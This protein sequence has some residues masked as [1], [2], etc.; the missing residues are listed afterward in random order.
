MARNI[1][2]G[3]AGTIVDN[4]SEIEIKHKIEELVIG[5]NEAMTYRSKELQESILSFKTFLNENS[6]LIFSYVY[7]VSVDLTKNQKMIESLG[8]HTLK[9]IAEIIIKMGKQ[10]KA[11]TRNHN[12]TNYRI[13]RYG[14]DT[15]LSR[16]IGPN[17]VTYSE[18]AISGYK[19]EKTL[20]DGISLHQGKY[21]YFK[22]SNSE[23]LDSLKNNTD[24]TFD[25]NSGVFIGLNNFI[26]Y[27]GDTLY[28]GENTTSNA[29]AND[30]I[31]AAVR[32]T[33][34]K[35]IVFPDGLILIH[36]DVNINK[37]LKVAQKLEVT[38]TSNFKDNIVIDKG[39]VTL[40]NTSGATTFKLTNSTGTIELAKNIII[41]GTG[42]S[43]D[44]NALTINKGSINLGFGNIILAKGDTTLTKGNLLLSEGN[45]VLS[46]G[47]L[48]LANG[49]FNLSGNQ[50]IDND[51]GFYIKQAGA[52][53]GT[54]S[55]SVFT[56]SQIRLGQ[57]S[58]NVSIMLGTGDNL[59]LDANTS[60][61]NI[62]KTFNSK[63]ETLATFSGAVKLEDT[64][65]IISKSLG[66]SIFSVNSSGN[67]NNAGTITS[68]G[69]IKS[70]EEIISLDGTSSFAKLNVAGETYIAGTLT[71]AKAVSLNNTLNVQLG[72]TGNTGT[73][74]TG[75]IGGCAFS[76]GGIMTGTA[77]AAYYADLAEYYTTDKKYE[78]G[79]ILQYSR[80]DLFFEAE[81]YKG[82]VLLGVVSDKP[83]QILNSGLADKE[84]P[85]NMIVLKGRSPVK[86]SNYCEKN[87]VVRGNAVIACTNDYGKAIV[88]DFNDYEFHK[89]DLEHRYIG[90]VLNADLTN[91]TVEVKF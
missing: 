65:T 4:I 62:Y 88:I 51:N 87:L 2:Q 80:Y 68:A 27:T 26:S 46:N 78:P 32:Q 7:G 71:V 43:S 11:Y 84:Q 54:N 74:A 34:I 73:F 55:S 67:I 44:E 17:Y 63:S 21:F 25:I 3:V 15:T 72:I 12:I 86:L 13:D 50:Y 91:N 37:N 18:N 77:T 22:D 14:H 69:K 41:A 45:A 9:Q 82:G 16:F 29:S 42:L 66:T 8:E 79:T 19:T 28:V 85:A 31:K 53:D 33:A 24:R 64:L 5:Y 35:N 81:L 76:G 52:S 30:E 39:D 23:S 59:I 61:Y 38:S 47:S 75:I 83:G 56:N 49:N 58:E 90:R 1:L 60:H 10:Y 70:S 36:G 40:I 89:L 48:T 6:S 57:N 20:H